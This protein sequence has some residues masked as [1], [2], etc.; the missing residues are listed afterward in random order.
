MVSI[1][2]Q[3]NEGWDNKEPNN[4]KGITRRKEGGYSKKPL[5]V[6]WWVGDV[7]RKV[8]VWFYAEQRATDVG[9][10]TARQRGK[11]FVVLF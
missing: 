5:G 7:N 6:V 8:L 10:N 11:K 2:S 1:L 4:N 3:G 9:K